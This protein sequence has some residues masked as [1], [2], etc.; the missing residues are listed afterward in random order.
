MSSPLHN[1]LQPFVTSFLLGPNTFLS[2]LFSHTLILCFCLHATCQITHDAKEA[3]L[4]ILFWYHYVLLFSQCLC[5]LPDI[6]QILEHYTFSCHLM[7]GSLQIKTCYWNPVFCRGKVREVKGSYFSFL[8]NGRE[9]YRNMCCEIWGSYIDV[10]EEFESSDP[11]CL[12]DL[13]AVAGLPES[14]LHL[15]FG[16]L[17]HH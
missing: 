2:A 7:P 11:W 4:H 10:F 5:L 13:F 1:F 16:D 6:T 12:V 15:S 9:I 14:Y 17:K 8:G 3:K